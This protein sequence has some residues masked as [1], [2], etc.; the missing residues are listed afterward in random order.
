MIYQKNIKGNKKFFLNSIVV[1]F[2]VVRREKCM[3]LI[4]NLF[5]QIPK[6]VKI[7]FI[8]AF[9]LG[10]LVH[11]Y[12][13]TNGFL[14][15]DSLYNFYSEQDM[16]KSGRFTLSYLAGI[17]SYFDLHYLNGLLA[18]VYLA[19][20]VALLVELFNLRSRLSIFVLALL[21]VGFP[22][23]SGVFGY[24][25]TADGYILANLLTTLSVF[26]LFKV[27]K[28]I[29]GLIGSIILVYIAIGT[30]QA[31][32][33]YFI[34]L[35]VVLF[36]REN[37][38]EERIRWK[39]Y[40]LSAV[41]VVT[42]LLAYVIHFKIYENIHGLTNYNGIN[43]AGKISLETIRLALEKAKNEFFTFFFN[44]FELVN[45]FEKLNVIY[46]VLFLALT[47]MLIVCNKKSFLNLFLVTGSI[48]LLPY[49]SHLIY[50]ISADVYYH[51]LMKQHLVFI[52]ILGIVYM[53]YLGTAKL[54]LKQAMSLI[55]LSILFV[56][57]FNN[58][59][60]TNIYYEKLSDVNQQTFSL[61][62]QV[63]YDLR[64]TEGYSSDKPLHVIG[65]PS[66]ALSIADRYNLKTPQNVG[67]PSKIVYDK[68]TLYYYMINE[69]G[70]KNPY[71]RYT[72]DYASEYEDE[73]NEL[74]VW[75]HE[76]SIKVI[77]DAIV[78]K[79]SEVN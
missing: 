12:M 6:R 56:I 42:G 35:V 29:V 34:T 36:I 9:V 47:L 40:I 72:P 31:N 24:M 65:Y 5:N 39:T 3:E 54:K 49:V 13:L 64:K 57:G 45:L 53:E 60:I 63:A 68:N 62:T 18:I 37:I 52:L 58:T 50:F 48:I 10:L 69:I 51:I 25:F 61:M 2:Y 1:N 70:L 75:P 15:H 27:N 21:Y 79:F 38:V 19:L 76:N 74:N 22:T 66:G 26:L 71:K 67:A 30:Y 4:S 44:D 55:M 23:I 7:S 77:G 33:T 20:T 59:V 11:L 17:S 16:S 28:R 41:S 8:T 32:L 73:I 46:F 78:I 14:N 43:Q